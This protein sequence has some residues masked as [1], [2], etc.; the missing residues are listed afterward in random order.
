M[1]SSLGGYT[2]IGC[3]IQ[4]VGVRAVGGVGYT[5]SRY[6]II[7]LEA[8]T[9]ER[10]SVLLHLHLLSMLRPV[11]KASAFPLT[12]KCRRAAPRPP[13]EGGRRRATAAACRVA[14][15]GG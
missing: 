14:R 5:D 15:L 6:Y 11:T 8:R 9:P 7:E 12:Q 1:C 10:E 2:V 13:G 4:G 3:S